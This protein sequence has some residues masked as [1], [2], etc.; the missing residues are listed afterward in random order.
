MP[1][2]GAL[3]VLRRAGIGIVAITMGLAAVGALYA[4]NTTIPAG[5]RGRLVTVGGT[6]LRVLETGQGRGVLLIHGSPG[7][8]EDWEPVIEG[9]SD[10]FH[11]S[12]PCTD[13]RSGS[14]ARAAA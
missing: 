6:P 8:I 7:S 11:V 14:T 2:A 3:R 4:P 13:P 12:T 9:L 10:S 5:H 1:V